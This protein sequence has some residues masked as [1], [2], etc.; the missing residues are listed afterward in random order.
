[1]S[2]ISSI[3]TSSS[4]HPRIMDSNVSLQTHNHG[5]E[6]THDKSR[7]EFRNPSDNHC[8]LSST[9]VDCGVTADACGNNSYENDDT[10]IRQSDNLSG[11][12]WEYVWTVQHF[13]VKEYPSIWKH[14]LTLLLDYLNNSSKCF[15]PN[16]KPQSSSDV[17]NDKTV[18][19]ENVQATARVKPRELR[20]V[21][22]R[23]FSQ[24]IYTAVPSSLPLSCRNQHKHRWSVT[25]QGMISSN[26]EQEVKDLWHILDSCDMSD[27]LQPRRPPS[28][29]PPPHS[30]LLP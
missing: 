11:R 18:I 8:K 25:D 12:K 28:Q 2:A 29:R 21:L 24:C 30:T 5:S 27:V 3:T 1:M 15:P 19:P 14:A 23:D 7:T 16:S 10:E 9:Q 20:R 4:N 13:S 17:A 26:A 6:T 22:R